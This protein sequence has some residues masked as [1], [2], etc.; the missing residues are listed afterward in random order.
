M[1]RNAGGFNLEDDEEGEEGEGAAEEGVGDNDEAEPVLDNLG[2]S[3]VDPAR[4]NYPLFRREVWAA[5]DQAFGIEDVDMKDAITAKYDAFYK[6]RGAFAANLS[7]IATEWRNLEA[8]AVQFGVKILKKKR[9]EYLMNAVPFELQ[10][11]LRNTLKQE[12]H[13]PKAILHKIKELAS[14]AGNSLIQDLGRSGLGCLVAFVVEV[15]DMDVAT[16][17]A[18]EVDTGVVPVGTVLAVLVSS[19]PAAA[20][21]EEDKQG[22]AEVDSEVVVVELLSPGK[23]ARVYRPARSAQREFWE[24]DIAYLDT[25]ASRS[26]FPEYYRK[27]II[28]S[29]EINRQINQAETGVKLKV[30]EDALFRFPFTE[31]QTGLCIHVHHRVYLVR[32]R[33]DG[34]PSDSVE[35][36]L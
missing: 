15:V 19:H 17:T 9:A 32:D 22:E 16:A 12:Q 21:E 33:E 20:L 34:S 13:D 23:R 4:V 28:W 5:V 2:L 14:A 1:Q 29:E 7:L 24:S 11:I 18:E 10:T 27:Y 35:P 25:G 30:H 3:E 8:Q 26:I 31:K 36:L 6:T